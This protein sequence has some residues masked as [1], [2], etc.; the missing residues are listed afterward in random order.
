MLERLFKL[1]LFLDLRLKTIISVLKYI[2]LYQPWRESSHTDL[3]IAMILRI[4]NK[5]RFDAASIEG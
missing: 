2:L 5:W 1:A 4:S 3:E